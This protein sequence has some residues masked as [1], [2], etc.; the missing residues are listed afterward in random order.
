MDTMKQFCKLLCLRRFANAVNVNIIKDYIDID[1]TF[2]YRYDTL[3]IWLKNKK[4]VCFQNWTHSVK[5]TVIF[6]FFLQKKK[7][8]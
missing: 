2:R 8:Y 6:C 5:V 4:A 3:A 7:T 1:M